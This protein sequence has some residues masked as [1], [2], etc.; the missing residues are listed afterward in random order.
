LRGNAALNRA[1]WHRRLCHIGADRLKQAIKGKVAT[2]L[3]VKSDAPAPSHCERCIRG[4]H[5]RDPFPQ[6]ASHRATS[7][8]QR[9]HS[10]LHQLPVLTSAGFR[11]RLL[12]IDDHWR[13]FSIFLLRKNSETFD[14]FTQFKAMVEKQFNKLILCLH[15]DKGGE[16]IGI[17]WDAFFAQHGIRRERT[18]KASPQ[19][20]GVAERLNRTLEE[21]LVAML[22]GA[23]LPARLWGERL[24]HLRHVIVRSPS[25]SIPLGTTPYEMA[26]K[27]KP[28]YWPLRVF[29]C[30]AWVHIQRKERRSLHDHAKPCV[31]IGCPED[32]KGL[33]LWD[34]SANGGRGSVI[35]SRDVVRRSSP[36]CRTSHT[37]PSP[38]AS[39]ALQTLVTL[40]AHQMTRRSPTRRIRRE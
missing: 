6:R 28:D 38:S 2:G 27:R 40:C 23:R 9:I 30:R 12:F 39:A 10:D 1:L 37:T 36:A 13:Y 24:N 22:N 26:H 8:F 33:K 4:K 17:K 19:Q 31:F 11:H 16:F 21:L 5:H 20:N 34:P 15:D 14:A 32:F 3:V 25:C 7:F 35:I 29:G 18:V